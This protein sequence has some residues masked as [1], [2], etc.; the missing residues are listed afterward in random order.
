[1]QI[2]V[3]SKRY[4]VCYLLLLVLKKKFSSNYSIKSSLNYFHIFIEVNWSCLA[5]MRAFWNF[6]FAMLYTVDALCSFRLS[7][8]DFRFIM[9]LMF[10]FFDIFVNLL[11]SRV[12]SLI[13]DIYLKN[14]YN[15]KFSNTN[16]LFYFK[17]FINFF[18]FY[19]MLRDWS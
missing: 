3:L 17:D 12:S 1:M 13:C 15:V 19:S 9:S 2:I 6:P 14:D 10:D 18:F 5:I 8:S 4:S 11:L 16:Q 7:I